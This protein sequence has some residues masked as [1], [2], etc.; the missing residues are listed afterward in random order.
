M[1][2]GQDDFGGARSLRITLAPFP[3][4]I[5]G[6][7]HKPRGP[8]S[9]TTSTMVY[10]AWRLYNKPS[11]LVSQPALDP[12]IRDLYQCPPPPLSDPP[13]PPSVKDPSSKRPRWCPP[14]PCAGTKT[15][16]SLSS[17]MVTL[18][19]ISPLDKPARVPG[20]LETWRRWSRSTATV[21]ARQQKRRLRA[22]S[23][24]LMYSY[25]DRAKCQVGNS[26]ADWES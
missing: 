15:G 2:T 5:I 7:Y 9:Q 16:S 19:V 21:R 8:H 10:E 26:F 13:F 24:S 18:A 3:R 6:T 14:T 12:P 17:R 1:E 4:F 11:R 20:E 25:R 23:S 22:K